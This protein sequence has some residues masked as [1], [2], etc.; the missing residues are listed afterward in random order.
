MFCTGALGLMGRTN[1][2]A[3]AV[4][5]AGIAWH[6]TLEI[7]QSAVKDNTSCETWGKI[8]LRNERKY[9]GGF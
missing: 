9:S 4:V 1:V 2:A 7:L 8:D 5:V 6:A 3:A